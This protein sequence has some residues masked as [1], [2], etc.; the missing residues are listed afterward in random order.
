MKHYIFL[1]LLIQFEY[2]PQTG[3][4]ILINALGPLGI[5]KLRTLSKGRGM[6]KFKGKSG[7]IG[8]IK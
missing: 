7:P 2:P 6:Y 3:D 4:Q 8:Q 1:E 5:F